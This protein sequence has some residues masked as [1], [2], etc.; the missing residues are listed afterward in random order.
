MTALFGS[1]THTLFIRPANLV[2]STFQIYLEIQCFFIIFP[3][4]IYKLSSFLPKLGNSILTGLRSP[5][6]SHHSLLLISPAS[7]EM[8]LG[9]LSPCHLFTQSSPTVLSLTVTAKDLTSPDSAIQFAS[10][11]SGTHFLELVFNHSS[12]ITRTSLLFLFMSAR[13]W[14]QSSCQMPSAHCYPRPSL[15]AL[16]PGRMNSMTD[17]MV[18][19]A[20]CFQVESAAKHLKEGRGES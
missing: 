3:A 15:P 16:Y 4:S 9:Y 8:P 2:C 19:L 14:P 11:V 20:L 1:H 12:I 7:R 10:D 5:S 6:L 17:A 13:I 18:S